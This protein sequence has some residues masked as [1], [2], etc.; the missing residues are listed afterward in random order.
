MK[1]IISI[2]LCTVLAVSLFSGMNCSIDTANAATNDEAAYPE[3]PLFLEE[4]DSDYWG[5]ELVSESENLALYVI[6]A[7]VNI[8]V[9]NK[10]SG[11]IWSSLVKESLLDEEGENKS[12]GRFYSLFSVGDINASTSGVT[13]AETFSNYILTTDETVARSEDS[14]MQIDYASVLNGIRVT[15][16]MADSKYELVMDIS[17]DKEKETLV[18][19]VDTSHCD[20]YSISK[21]WVT[22]NVLPYFGAAGD[23]ENG[24]VFYPDG[25][26][27]IAEFTPHHSNV[28]AS[29]TLPFYSQE[30]ASTLRLI[31]NESNGI[32]PVMYPVFGMKRGDDAFCAIVTD[33][34]CSSGMKFS[35]SGSL[36]KFYRVHP[37]FYL[38]P[39]MTKFSDLESESY[40][41]RGDIYEEYYRVEYH[42][43]DGDDADYSGMAVTYRNYL[44]DKGLLND[45]IKDGDKMPLALDLYMNT[46]EDTI[47]GQKSVVATNFSQASEI[48]TELSKKGIEDIIVN[49]SS[50]Q[51]YGDE[52]GTVNSAASA[53][54][55]NGGF[56]SFVKTAKDLGYDVFAQV[57]T[58]EAWTNTT[59]FKASR[60]AAQDL[61]G[62]S[63]IGNS[64]L[65]APPAIKQRYEELYIDYFKDIG[66]SGLN[67]KMLGYYLYYYNYG[68]THYN[69]FVTEEI[70][71]NLINEAKKDLGKTS[72]WY[73]NQYSL[74]SADWIYDLPSTDTGYA[75]TTRAVPFAQIVLHG[76]IPY[77]AIAGNM[78][79]D[80][81]VQTLRWI[82]YGYVPYYKITYESTSKLIDTAMSELFSAKFSDWADNIEAKY[83]MMTESVGYLYN[84]PIK[85]HSM[86]TDN[87]YV[88]IYEDGSKV[89]VNYSA[90]DYK[91]S[92]GVVNAKSHLVV[93]G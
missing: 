1:R 2:L 72:V 67:F 45:A 13:L 92:D 76:Y 91:T 4:V 60:D 69:R 47:F 22:I 78:F 6:D 57:N 73:G 46:Y 21:K 37:V 80:D 51:K 44:L 9:L 3:A 88:T 30:V 42:F 11:M 90:R 10:K 34:A 66:V 8:A 58:V 41:R 40:N 61:E 70:F 38:M 28:E 64:Y 83:K 15:A 87:V 23:H 24:Y 48:L 25:S 27:T 62:L 36:T 31:E 59:K 16:F 74:A 20:Y 50:W 7:S 49:V 75:N 77:S 33:G 35:P 14:Y 19:S 84:V 86:I 29:R 55:G 82:E 32:M 52:T 53:I 79:Y 71:T 12:L 18:V 93:K 65:I 68:G 39:S 89:Y 63:M 43:L 56:K 26:G 54:G 17:L 81:A 5:F 85:K